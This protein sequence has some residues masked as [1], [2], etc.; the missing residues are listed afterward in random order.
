MF[1]LRHEH[2]IKYKNTTFF[3]NSLRSN[4]LILK[5]GAFECGKLRGSRIVVVVWHSALTVQLVNIT[6]KIVSSIPNND[7]VNSIYP[8]VIKF[9]YTGPE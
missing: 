4:K 3:Q 7:E 8:Y 6:T 1:K 5:N 9:K 2:K